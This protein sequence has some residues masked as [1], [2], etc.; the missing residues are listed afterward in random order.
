MQTDN[1]K[2]QIL[3]TMEDGFFTIDHKWRFRCINRKAAHI[4]G[5]E[6][7]E[8]VDKVIWEVSPEIIGTNL[9]KVYRQAMEL[10][11][12][13][14][15]EM[16]GLLTG[17]WYNIIAFPSA[18]GISVYWQDISEQKEAENKLAFQGQL[19]AQVNDAIIVRDEH[20]VITYWNK[21]AERILGWAAYDSYSRK[22]K[23]PIQDL[24]GTLIN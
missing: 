1:Q 2:E 24:W 12:A 18:E 3:D 15:I 7:K 16:Q 4:F 21:T 11:A 6:P 13:Q 14:R 23:I 19:L 17:S 5:L 10:Q 22:Q 20:K 8:L 9:E